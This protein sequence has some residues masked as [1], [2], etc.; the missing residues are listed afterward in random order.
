MP[1]KLSVVSLGTRLGTVMGLKVR[2]SFIL[3]S[4]VMLQG[5][6]LFSICHSV[7]KDQP[8]Q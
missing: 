3:K 7:R 1:E 4:I 2:F 8:Q 6:R 5:W